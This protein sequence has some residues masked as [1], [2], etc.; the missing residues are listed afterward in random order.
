MKSRTPFPLVPARC[1]GTVR[2]EE[3]RGR[4][5]E[6]STWA[7]AATGRATPEA[8][9]RRGGAADISESSLHFQILSKHS[10]TAL[11]SPSKPVHLSH[12]YIKLGK[13]GSYSLNETHK[14]YKASRSAV[15][16]CTHGIGR[17]V[18]GRRG[19]AGSAN[20][21]PE[22]RPEQI[23]QGRNRTWEKTRFFCHC[24]LAM[25]RFKQH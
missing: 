18:H 6:E 19:G 10:S 14:M 7:L 13:S 21:G 8:T 23:F 15:A 9:V 25:V 3:G 2:A 16:S 20:R 17:A 12:G 1:S 4:S 5:Q 22:W 11:N 24:S